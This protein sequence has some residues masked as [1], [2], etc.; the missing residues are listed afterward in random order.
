MNSS[1]GKQRARARLSS[2]VYRTKPPLESVS[3]AASSSTRM[4]SPDGSLAFIVPSE[5][6]VPRY[7]RPQPGESD[8]IAAMRLHAWEKLDAEQMNPHLSR[9][10]IHGQNVTIARLELRKGGV[11][12]EHSHLNEQVSMV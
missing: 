4:P 5:Y 9:K 11:V 7:C 3:D 6:A 2:V 1:S 12:P 10:C 8:K